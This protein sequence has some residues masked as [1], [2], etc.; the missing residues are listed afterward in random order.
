M[1]RIAVAAVSLVVAVSVVGCS[2]GKSAE[3]G[4]H[5][6]SPGASTSGTAPAGGAPA[7]LQSGP[8]PQAKYTVQAQPA[9]G[10]C[11]Y[12]FTS[13]KQPL[14]DPK[15]TPGALNPKVTQANLKS[16]ICVPGY[17]SKIRPPASIT[18]AEKT[19]NAKSY[20]YTGPMN[21]AEYD[22]YLPLSWGGDPDD[23]RN[24]WVEPPS[25]DHKSGAGPNNPKDL[26]E[27]KGHAAICSGKITLA[28]AQ[29]AITTD[30]TT[31]LAKLGVK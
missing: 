13:D 21:D 10:A 20:D 22:H 24:L 1:R 2:G 31:A 28:A 11:H 12:R 30:W 5:P 7:A 6:G 16:T 19:A 15:C 25:P 8:G 18:G 4:K 9:P 14:P 29:E 26:V 27:A 17:T 23:A 3:G